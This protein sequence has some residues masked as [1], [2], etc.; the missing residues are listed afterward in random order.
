MPLRN[1]SPPLSESV[2]KGCWQSNLFWKHYVVERSVLIDPH[3]LNKSVQEKLGCLI[4][5]KAQFTP[6]YLGLSCFWACLC[7]SKPSFTNR[8]QCCSVMLIV[9]PKQGNL[10]TFLDV[11]KCTCTLISN[12]VYFVH[13]RKCWKLWAIRKY[14]AT[15]FLFHHKMYVCVHLPLLNYF[16]LATL[17]AED[18][19]KEQT[20][21]AVQAVDIQ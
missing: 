16:T 6:E 18:Q 17:S 12:P 21:P 3:W 2:Y 14:H 7:P 19:G 9:K 8:K 1:T 5:I 13:L 10:S 15:F 20:V 4:F 11:Q